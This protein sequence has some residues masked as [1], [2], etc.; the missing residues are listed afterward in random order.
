VTGLMKAVATGHTVLVPNA[1]LAAALFDALER[2]Y[3]AGGRDVWPTPRVR[4]FGSW[5]N[6]MYASRQLADAA[7]PRL[8]GQIDE[9]ELWQ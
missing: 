2:A 4:D 8:L 7:S 3:L 6:E 9:R 5:L 1:E